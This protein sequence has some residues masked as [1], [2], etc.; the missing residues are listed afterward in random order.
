[1][2]QICC[3]IRLG[4]WIFS[5]NWS[6]QVWTVQKYFISFT[7]HTWFELHQVTMLLMLFIGSI[8]LLSL[9]NTDLFKP[10][11]VVNSCSLH[12]CTVQLFS[13]LRNGTVQ[14]KQCNCVEYFQHYIKEGLGFLWIYQHIH[15]K[16]I[17]SIFYG[18]MMLY[19]RCFWYEK[20]LSSRKMIIN[21]IMFHD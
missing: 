8:L 4:S 9:F 1:M 21:I 20:E 17:L 2:S 15:V 16:W 12:M 18:L 19:R 6:P 13:H 7:M 11:L 10:A 3:P 5:T 14:N